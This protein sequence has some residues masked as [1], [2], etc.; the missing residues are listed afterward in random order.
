LEDSKLTPTYL[1]IISLSDGSMINSIGANY[2][3][4][5][6]FSLS[7]SYVSVLGEPSTKLGQ[8]GSSAGIYLSGEWVF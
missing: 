2:D 3:F 7:F 4:T 6:D 1:G 8:M 5:D